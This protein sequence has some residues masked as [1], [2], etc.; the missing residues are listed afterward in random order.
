MKVATIIGARPQFI[1]A[2]ALSQEIKKQSKNNFKE[3]IIHTGQHFDYEMSEQFFKELGIPKPKYNLSI[4]G[5]THGKNTGRMIENIEKVL[6]DEKPDLVLL[7]GDTDST[8]SGAIAASKLFVPIAHVEAGLRSFNK[9]QPEEINRLI[10]DHLSEICFAP[11]EQAIINLKNEG[12]SEEKI[13]RT[14]DVMA[15]TARIFGERSGRQSSI[16]KKYSIQK[17][18]YILSTIHRAENTNDIKLLENILNSLLFI[19]KASNNKINIDLP[20]I[21]PLHPRT[22]V[23]I[24]RNEYLSLLAKQLKIIKPLSFL[25]MIFIL[26]NAKLVVTDSGGVQKEAYLHETPCVTTRKETEWVELIKSEWNILANP[27]NYD[28]LIKAYN[29]QLSFNFDKDHPDFYGKGFASIDIVKKIK[30][31]LWIKG[32]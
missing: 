4:S 27:E 13:V 22:E 25:E 20:V 30:D 26:K 21:L 2:A 8:L 24:R 31:F 9:K 29:K 6:M 10:T 3:I 12:I 15:D 32:C 18:Q 19:S 5:G 7:Y 16:L 23:I 28:Q 17:N 14:E 11:T 1:K